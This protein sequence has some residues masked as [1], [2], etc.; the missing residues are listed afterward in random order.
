MPLETIEKLIRLFISNGIL[1]NHE[2]PRRGT[3]FVTAKV[4]KGALEIKKGLAENLELG[5]LDSYRDWGHSYDYTEA[6]IKL[7]DLDEP[8]DIV[9]ST[10]K[11]NS[12]R[13]LC[14]Y[15]FNKL[16]L[17]YKDHVKINPA[18]LRPQ[19]LPFLC[20]DSTKAKKET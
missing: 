11:T 2:S 14:K 17:N 13:D 6:M 20:G 3:N 16:G 10:G 7:L 9:I 15:T 8:D 18:F 1:F 12:V 19:E 5:N 4:I